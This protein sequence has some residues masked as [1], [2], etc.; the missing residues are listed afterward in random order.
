MKTDQE[1]NN[2][3]GA[4]QAQTAS[5]KDQAHTEVNPNVFVRERDFKTEATHTDAV[6]GIC[7]AGNDEF[8]TSSADCSL[9][10]WDKFTQGV[11]YTYEMHEPLSSMNVTG[12]HGELLV[13][14]QG[15]GHLIVFG[16]REKN[17]LD[18]VQW[19]HAQRVTQVVSLGKLKNKYFATRCGDGH[20]NIYSSLA[21]PDRIA[22]LF[23]FDGDE[24]ALAHLQPKE[25]VVEEAP[26]KRRR[27]RKREDGEDGEEG[28]GDEEEGEYDDEEG[29][30]EEEE[31]PVEENEDD[32]E[33]KDEK[34]K[35]EPPVAPL[36]VG[37]P[38]PSERDRMIEITTKALIQSSSTMLAVSCFNEKQVLICNVDI[39]TRSRSIKQTFKTENNPT[40]LYQIDDDHLL[41][42]TSGQNFEIWNID[43]TAEQA[44]FV[45]RVH[46]KVPNA[47]EGPSQIVKLENPSPMITDGIIDDEES[48]T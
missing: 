23:N 42:G 40:Y 22:Q 32:E 35:V 30:E 43:P 7:W 27:R 3:N 25:E 17:Q 39:K 19:A 41:V 12:E 46:S 15:D 21:H 31:A 28:E 5:Q 11:A 4:S 13:C 18:I 10:L 37:R 29:E 20:V 44:K 48:K 38:E 2:N 33:K 34:P 36:L 14:G 45:S 24:D 9:K 26:K 1:S 8:L 16:L 47:Q 6:N